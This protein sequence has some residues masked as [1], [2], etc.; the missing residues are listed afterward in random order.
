MFYQ[1]KFDEQEVKEFTWDKF[2]NDFTVDIKYFRTPQI[3]A[4]SFLEFLSDLPNYLI[5]SFNGSYTEYQ[6]NQEKAQDLKKLQSKIVDNDDNINCY[7]YDL[8]MIVQ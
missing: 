8:L 7:G 4:S 6:N 3:L 1:G 2:K 5:V